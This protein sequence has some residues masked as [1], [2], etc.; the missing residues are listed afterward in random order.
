VRTLTEHPRWARELWAAQFLFLRLGFAPANI[1]WNVAKMANASNAERVYALL[2][3]DDGKEFVL[4]VWEPPKGYVLKEMQAAYG[5]IIDEV[6][7]LTDEEFEA[8]FS[9]TQASSYSTLALVATLDAKGIGCPSFPMNELT[10]EALRPLALP[11]PGLSPGG[12]A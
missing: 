1:Q 10:R 2:V 9:T 11:A 6:P 4:A 3:L 5:R 8:F 7:S 12:T